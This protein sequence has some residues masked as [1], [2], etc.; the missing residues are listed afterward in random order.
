MNLTRG[1][2]EIGHFFMLK[3]RVVISASGWLFRH[4]PQNFSSRPG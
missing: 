4:I 3:F 2:H 1:E